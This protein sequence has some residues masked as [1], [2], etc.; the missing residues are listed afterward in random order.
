MEADDSLDGPWIPT[1]KV[2]NGYS[3]T[4]Y[5]ASA[6]HPNGQASVEGTY[7]TSVLAMRGARALS[8][9]LN[10][11]CPSGEDHYGCIP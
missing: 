10:K 9:T 4:F 2:R 11:L 7:T 6:E 1:I 8:V 5:H 3:E